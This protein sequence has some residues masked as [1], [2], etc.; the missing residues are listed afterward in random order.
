MEK[1]DCTECPT[2]HHCCKLGACVDLE[3]AKKILELKLKGE[4]FHLEKDSSFPSGYSIGTSY[5]DGPCTFLADDG[6]C[7]IHK[8][9]YDLKPHYCREFPYEDGKLSEFSDVLCLLHEGNS[10]KHKMK[11]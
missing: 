5:D 2:M 6:L 4:F 9:D 8:V 1:F 11:E 7:S 10:K 3:E